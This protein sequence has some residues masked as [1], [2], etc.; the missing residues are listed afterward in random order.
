MCRRKEIIGGTR[1]LYRCNAL[2]RNFVHLYLILYN[3]LYRDFVILLGI[4]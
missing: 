2:Q 4:V 3:V 1:M